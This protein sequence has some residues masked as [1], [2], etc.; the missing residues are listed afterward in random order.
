MSEFVDYLHEVFAQFGPIRTRKMF[1]G[2]GVYHDDLMFGLIA[3]DEL[4][5]KTDE[6][7]RN[8]FIELDLGPFEF[9][10]DGKIMQMSYYRAPEEIFDDPEEAARWANSAYSAARRAA[11][12]KP[13]KR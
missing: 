6:Q 10:K 9:N 11:K 12:N 1:G 7:N 4:Y 13:K 2:H 8:N 3:D 5:L